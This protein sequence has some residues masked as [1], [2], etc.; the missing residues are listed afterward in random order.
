[1]RYKAAN[2]MGYVFI[3]LGIVL[4]GISIICFQSEINVGTIL[5]IVIIIIGF[6]IRIIF[7]RLLFANN[8]IAAGNGYCTEDTLNNIISASLNDNPE[9]E[10]AMAFSDVIKMVVPY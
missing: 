1:M 10:T 9:I 8:I 2:L 3:L 7:Y 6:L 5:G 4:F